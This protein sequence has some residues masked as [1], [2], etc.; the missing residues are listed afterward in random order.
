VGIESTQNDCCRPNRLER[1]C[2]L[3]RRRGQTQELQ[4]DVQPFVKV[5]PDCKDAMIAE[6]SEYDWNT[7]LFGLRS[8]ILIWKGT[9]RLAVVGVSTARCLAISAAEKR[10]AGYAG[11]WQTGQWAGRIAGTT[12]HRACLNYRYSTTLYVREGRSS[13][14]AGNIR[15]SSDRRVETGFK[16]LIPRWGQC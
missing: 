11:D 2:L 3:E 10:Q 8:L 12:A 15:Q 13:K 5:R 16:Q 7:L 4:G 6:A 9:F 1:R 14:L